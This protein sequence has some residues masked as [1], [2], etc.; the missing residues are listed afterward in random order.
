MLK[1]RRSRLMINRFQGKLL[2]RFVAYWFIYQF[3]MWNFL[4]GWHVLREGRGNPAEQHL[5]FF[6]AQYP[7]LIVFAILVPFFAW[8]ALKLSHRVAGPI[9]RLRQ[10]IRTIIAGQ[11][12]RRVKLRDGDHLTEVAEDVNEMLLTLEERGAITIDRS[13][14]RTKV[15]PAT[16]PGGN[17]SCSD[18]PAESLTS[19]TV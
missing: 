16:L 3:T 12:V 10:T 14:P 19:Q 5:R 18:Q 8:D 11:P 9:Y 2:W 4:F 1:N 17:D 7:M 15:K 13:A 6:Q